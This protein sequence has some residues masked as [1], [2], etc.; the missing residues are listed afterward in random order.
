VALRLMRIADHDQQLLRRVRAFLAGLEQLSRAAKPQPRRVV[1][2][3]LGSVTL[4]ARVHSERG[5]LVLRRER[6]Q[7]LELLGVVES[8]LGF[9]ARAVRLLEA[10][11]AAAR[12]KVAARLNLALAQARSLDVA[13][14]RRTLAAIS[15]AQRRQNP[16][17]ANLLRSLAL[18]EARLAAATKLGFVVGKKPP[19]QAPVLRKLAEVYVLLKTP[20]R[21]ARLLR[22]AIELQP[23]DR[24]L[25]VMLALELAASGD[26]RGSLA[27]IALARQHFGKEAGLDALEQRARRLYEGWRAKVNR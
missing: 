7:I 23:A 26:L 10:S 9:D 13:A 25:R 14:A 24:T 27:T 2:L 12:D 8:R 3:G 6:A 18:V 1:T 16:R 5:L 19:D 20:A 11:L 22:R 17:V 15:A 4:R 21:A